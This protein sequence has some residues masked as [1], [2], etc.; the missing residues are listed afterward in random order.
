MYDRTKESQNWSNIPQHR[1]QKNRPELNK[2]KNLKSENKRSL[3][4]RLIGNGWADKIVKKQ[5]QKEIPNSKNQD[6]KLW[7]KKWMWSC[8]KRLGMLIKEKPKNSPIN[9][10]TKF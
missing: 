9:D 8:E 3:T 7:N 5:N 6:D 10:F 4:E 2:N 1:P